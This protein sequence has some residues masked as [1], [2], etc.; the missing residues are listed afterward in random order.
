MCLNFL[1]VL[2][3]VILHSASCAIVGYF[4][5]LPG[6]LIFCH[7]GCK[8]RYEMCRIFHRILRSTL[9][10]GS[11]VGVRVRLLTGLPKRLSLILGMRRGFCLLRNVQNISLTH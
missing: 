7:N 8:F 6:V 5:L 2:R 1:Y 4:T 11:S 10:C 9:S 3:S